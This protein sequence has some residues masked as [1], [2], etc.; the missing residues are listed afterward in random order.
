MYLTNWAKLQRTARL[1]T[2]YNLLGELFSTI[3]FSITLGALLGYI[4]AVVG[5]K[6]W[7]RA[8]REE[9][10]ERQRLRGGAGC[11]LRDKKPVESIYSN[12]KACCNGVVG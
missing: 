12:K 6:F 2:R 1:G 11:W 8:E 10:G 9:V 4:I 3:R 5:K 7:E